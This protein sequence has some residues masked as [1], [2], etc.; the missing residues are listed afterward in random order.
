MFRP[1]PSRNP[2]GA[3][4]MIAHTGQGRS[5]DLAGGPTLPQP[6]GEPLRAPRSSATGFDAPGVRR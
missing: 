1:G 4:R 6:A 5:P 3:V 2:M